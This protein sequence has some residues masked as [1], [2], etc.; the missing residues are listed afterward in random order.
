M[1][2]R[3][4]PSLPQT[5]AGLI[6]WAYMKELR[7]ANNCHH[8]LRSLPEIPEKIDVWITTDDNNIPAIVT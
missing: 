1:G 8:R 6:Q 7:V 3:L 5:T 2:R 4:C